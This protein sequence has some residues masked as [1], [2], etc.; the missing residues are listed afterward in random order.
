MEHCY[1]V[2]AEFNLS[3]VDIHNFSFYSRIY[4]RELGC[5]FLPNKIV[6]KAGALAQ[7]EMIRIR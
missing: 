3:E 2:T 1:C 6:Y 4:V 7:V 5:Y